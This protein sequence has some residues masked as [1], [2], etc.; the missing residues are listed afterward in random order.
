MTRESDEDSAESSERRIRRPSLLEAGDGVRK[1]EAMKELPP[2]LSTA[3]ARPSAR[4]G[5]HAEGELA[6]MTS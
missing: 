5:G 4:V 3:S 2:A 1:G 6:M